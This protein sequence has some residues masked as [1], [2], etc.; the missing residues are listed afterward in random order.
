MQRKILWVLQVVLVFVLAGALLL[1]NSVALAAQDA[2]ADHWEQVS[3]VPVTP[4]IT[5]TVDP[6]NP[7]RLYAGGSSGTSAAA[8][9][10]DD[11]GLNWTNISAGLSGTIVRHIAVTLSEVYIVCAKDSS[12]PTKSDIFRSTDQGAH[13]T[14]CSGSLQGKN[15]NDIV[16]DPS[17]PAILYASTLGTPT[18][19]WR[20]TDSGAHWTKISAGTMAID[21][22]TPTTIY[23]GDQMGVLRSTD[24]G[25]HW[26]RLSTSGLTDTYVAQIVVDPVKPATIYVGTSHPPGFF[27]IFRSDDQGSHW[28]KIW[29]G[30]ILLHLAVDEKGN[31]TL[32]AATAGGIVRSDDNGD[33]WASA[34]TG[35]TA[36]NIWLWDMTVGTGSNATAYAWRTDDNKLS[37]R[38]AAMTPSIDV[39]LTL[40]LNKIQMTVAPRDGSATM[41]TLDAAPL[42]GIGNRT[43]VPL[44]AVAEA[45]GVTVT[46]DATAHTATIT[47]GMSNLTLT[48]GKATAV[49]NGLDTPIDTNAKVVPLIVAGRM[50]LPV[51]FVAE[52]LGATV[53]YNQVTKTI[54]MTYLAY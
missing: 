39:T 23:A 25:A 37:H 54:T 53:N 15:I 22:T 41:V 1:P 20:S 4:L 38:S 29:D 28:T 30:S 17:T 10:S 7:D 40:T 52:S 36:Q 50:L 12:A 49:V 43:L 5:L 14:N 13:W 27:S 42:L 44:R 47:G 21:P 48:I 3:T 11:G 9:R 19:F 31:R 16:V 51:R 18:G 2:P 45:F 34:F 26:K 32:Y 6:T 35:L 46:W 8:F 33:H 24:R